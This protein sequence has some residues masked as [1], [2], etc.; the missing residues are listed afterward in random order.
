MISL[1]AFKKKLVI[2]EQKP[3]S[4][5]SIFCEVVHFQV[6]E[7]HFQTFRSSSYFLCNSERV[8]VQWSNWLEDPEIHKSLVEQGYILNL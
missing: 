4:C 2:I 5:G 8:I 7:R 1:S 6:G 3:L